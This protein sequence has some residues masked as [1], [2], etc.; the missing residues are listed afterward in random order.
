LSV[1][2]GLINLFL[3]PMLDG[4]HLLFYAYEA[5]FGK[6]P[7]EKMMEYSY[8]IGLSL[9]LGLMIFVTWNDISRKLG[10]YFG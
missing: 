6:A 2:L 1:N 10:D 4:G 8:R 7:G 3:I 9:I 5:V